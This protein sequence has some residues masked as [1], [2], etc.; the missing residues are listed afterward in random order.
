MKIR[1]IAILSTQYTQYNEEFYNWHTWYCHRPKPGKKN[2]SYTKYTEY[3]KEYYNWHTW[4]CHRPKIKIRM[5]LIQ[6]H[7]TLT[8]R[9][10]DQAKCVWNRIKWKSS[11]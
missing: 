8:L 5:I 11:F 4:H 1:I 6:I 9:I 7:R 10:C 2:D 3:S